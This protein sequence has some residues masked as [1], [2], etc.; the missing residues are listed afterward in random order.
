MPSNHCAVASGSGAIWT[1][2]RVRALIGCVVGRTLPPNRETAKFAETKFFTQIFY[3]TSESFATTAARKH[4]RTLGCYVQRAKSRA[5]TCKERRRILHSCRLSH[6]R[7]A[8][9][10][11]PFRCR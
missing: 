4:Q 11:L 7:F 8:S 2:S 1:W 9:A 3:S 10:P 6:Y 5:N